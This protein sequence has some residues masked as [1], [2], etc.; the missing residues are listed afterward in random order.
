MHHS[1]NLR[2][3]LDLITDEF[4]A[5]WRTGP[6]PQLSDNLA[7]H[8]SIDPA[9]LL[10]ELLLVEMDM[11]QA[12]G[13][14][15]R[16]EEYCAAFPEQ[17]A[18]VHEAFAADQTIALAGSAQETSSFTRAQ[19]ASDSLDQNL[20][21]QIRFLAPPQQPDEIGRL[22]DYRVLEVMGVGGMGVVFRA[23]DPHLQRLVALKAMKPAVAASRSSRDRFFREARA[24]AALDH[25]HI[26][27]IYQ[28][29]EDREIP[30]I[31]MQYLCGESLQTRLKR[32]GSLE[33]HAVIQIGREVALGLA[34]GSRR[35][36]RRHTRPTGRFARIA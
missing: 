28:V 17:T 19:L 4:E 30:F 29:D 22:G 20:R 14:T 9:R 16:L 21:K 3:Q 6:R 32:E 13:E 33:Q 5:A 23:E 24:A 18:V 31:A 36:R 34:F 15:P 25:D 2:E 8:L 35:R 11:R 10:Y 27:S 26:V 1:T 7:E 12:A